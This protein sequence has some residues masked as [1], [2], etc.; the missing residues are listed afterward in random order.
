MP[1]SCYW[2]PM[3]RGTPPGE[4]I[5]L[6]LEQVARVAA[7][8]AIDAEKAKLSEEQKEHVIFHANL[9]ERWAVF[10]WY[11]PGAKQR[12]AFV[13]VRASVDRN[14]RQVV[15][16]RRPSPTSRPK[17]TLVLTF[18]VIFAPFIIAA[19]FLLLHAVLDYTTGKGWPPIEKLTYA[20]PFAWVISQ[21]MVLTSLY[22]VV[23]SVPIGLPDGSLLFVNRVSLKKSQIKEA[24]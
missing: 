17:R 9:G 7:Q 13:V 5:L 16:E 11:V 8:E 6:D 20:A 10:D 14:T 4:R 22:R 19:C 18:F 2:W 1:V 3:V 12:D 23:T 15:V 24:S 21:L